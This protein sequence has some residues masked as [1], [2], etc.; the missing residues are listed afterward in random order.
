MFVVCDAISSGFRLRTGL[1]AE[2]TLA[3]TLAVD[4]SSDNEDSRRNKNNAVMKSVDKQH[5]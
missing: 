4:G 3:I 5:S 1:I 2:V